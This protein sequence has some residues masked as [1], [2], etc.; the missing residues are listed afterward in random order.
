MNWIVGIIGG[1]GIAYA[2]WKFT[3][4][5]KAKGCKNQKERLEKL[6]PMYSDL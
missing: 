4:K 5:P 3:E 2:I 6:A 1:L